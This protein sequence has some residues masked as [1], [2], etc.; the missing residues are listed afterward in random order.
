LLLHTSAHV[1]SD[2]A[3]FWLEDSGGP[4]PRGHTL[5][6]AEEE[7]EG[8][9]LY[10]LYSHFDPSSKKL[11]FIALHQTVLCIG[12]LFVCFWFFVLVELGFEFRTFMLAKQH[13]T[14]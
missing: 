10:V 11:K 4:K 2:S 14:A 5:R 12:H 3:A 7:V 9:Q 13:S 6:P 1:H 8:Q